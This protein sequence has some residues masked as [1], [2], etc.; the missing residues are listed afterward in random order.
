MDPE[1]VQTFAIK[2]RMK[3]MHRRCIFCVCW[4]AQSK[5]FIFPYS[6]WLSSKIKGF[7]GRKLW[8][9][10]PNFMFLGVLKSHCLMRLT[11]KKGPKPP[12]C[13]LNFFSRGTKDKNFD[14]FPKKFG[15][16]KISHFLDLAYHF[17]HSLIKIEH[18]Y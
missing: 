8:T 4:I 12:I 9:T 6:K 15:E 18:M 13:I 1:R 10:Y 5:A 7:S 2:H 16:T 17:L 3:N 11:D 14:F